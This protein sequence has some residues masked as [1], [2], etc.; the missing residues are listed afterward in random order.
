MVN[1]YFYMNIDTNA[2]SY[3]YFLF[4]ISV[5]SHLSVLGKKSVASWEVTE[6]VR[7]SAED[8]VSSS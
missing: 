6:G 5:D 2:E 4:H 1:E 7:S 3:Q 8:C